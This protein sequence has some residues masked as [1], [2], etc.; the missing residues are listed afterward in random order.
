MIR[1]IAV[2]LQ[3]FSHFGKAR[4]EAV[5]G[6]AKTSLALPS[7]SKSSATMGKKK[8]KEKVRCQVLSWGECN[9]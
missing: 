4:E 5:R 3:G 2:L 6:L 9:N 8:G 7:L 1:I